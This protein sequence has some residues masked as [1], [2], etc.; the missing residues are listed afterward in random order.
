MASESLQITLFL[1]KY[2]QFI[3]FYSFYRPSS[4][5]CWLFLKLHTL[6]VMF[7]YWCHQRHQ[8][9][10]LPSQFTTEV[11]NYP[12]YCWK[13]CQGDVNN[14]VTEVTL[15][16]VHPHSPAWTFLIHS[17]SWVLPCWGHCY[18]SLA[19]SWVPRA[20]CI[21]L[22]TRLCAKYFLDNPVN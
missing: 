12:R 18:G 2:I 22:C 6:A 3:F 15:F 8:S 11:Y 4:F 9:S 10:P 19:V 14:T 17:C 16:L 7:L 13:W 20:R 21:L 1:L 5:S